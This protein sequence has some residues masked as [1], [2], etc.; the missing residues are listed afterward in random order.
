MWRPGDFYRICERTGFKVLASQTKKEWT[1]RI[2]RRESF[3][4]R[5]PQDFVKGVSD[6]Q[7]V[8][9]PRPEPTID[10]FSG[11]L[12]SELKSLAAAGTKNLVLNDTSRMLDGDNCWI[13]LDNGYLHRTRIEQVVDRT[14][15]IIILPLSWSASVGNL[16]TDV[17]AV[18]GG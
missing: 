3:E 4:K 7:W 5:Q 8:P 16:F 11:P 1:G 10:N 13:L 15:L 2:V 6:R 9:D 17:S 18:S 12:T 14:H